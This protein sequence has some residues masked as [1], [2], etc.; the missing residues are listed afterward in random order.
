MSIDTLPSKYINKEFSYK[1]R[2][3]PM[4]K[5]SGGKRSEIK[6]FEHFIPKNIDTYIEPFIG[7]GALFFYLN[8]TKNIINDTHDEIYNFYNVASTSLAG[9]LSHL[10]R[11][12]NT[13]ECY[14][15]VRNEVPLEHTYTPLVQAARFLYLRKTCFRGMYRTN[16]SG[17]FNIPFG[18]YK[19]YTIPSF[20]D[21]SSYQSLLNNTTICHRDF[22]DMFSTYGSCPDNFIF[23]D[24]PY[25]SE[26]S[27]YGADD[28]TEDDHIRLSTCFYQSKAKVMIV[29]G[30]HPTIRRLYADSI[31]FKYHK[32]YAFKIK[33]N[34]V[35]DE[36]NNHHLI[37]TNYPITF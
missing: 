23:C 15:M 26:F 17:H 37:I 19:T 33:E 6:F 1:D 31:R 18:R 16:K 20:T 36:I 35:G 12:E 10:E 30:D 24:P 28:F 11:W 3:I 7:A 4:F 32:K 27:K 5:W 29:V 9:I 8:H 34:R 13:E 2:L 21:W 14:Y 25:L 22:A